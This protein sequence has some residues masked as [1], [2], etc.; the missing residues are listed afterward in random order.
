MKNKIDNFFYLKPIHDYYLHFLINPQDSN[1][2]KHP[3]LNINLY[4]CK[5]R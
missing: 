2:L 4:Y 1:Q 5:R 3:Q